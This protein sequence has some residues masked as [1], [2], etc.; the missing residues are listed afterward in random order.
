MYRVKLEFAV[1][2]ASMVSLSCLA[3]NIGLQLLAR[4]PDVISVRNGSGRW[5]S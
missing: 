1:R 5:A 4:Q 3:K 2:K